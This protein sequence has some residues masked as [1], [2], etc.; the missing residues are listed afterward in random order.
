VPT[1]LGC[2]SLDGETG[3]SSVTVGADVSTVKVTG[4]LLPA[5]FPSELCWTATAVNVPF[6]SD[7]LASPEDQLP[8]VPVAVA[9][10]TTVPLALDPA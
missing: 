5:G 9:V 3:C 4:E 7:G 2:V 8:P 10:D 1:K 6:V